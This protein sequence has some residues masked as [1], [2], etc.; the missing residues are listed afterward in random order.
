MK[1]FTDGQWLNAPDEWK[2]A[3]GVLTMKTQP[4]TDFWRK[5][6]Y[7]F[8]RDSGHFLGVKVDASFTAWLRV[9]GEFRAL[10]DQAGLMI[11]IDEQRWVKT[12]V[13]FTDGELFLSTVIT[14]GKS[15]WSVS[16][17]FKALEDF[18][19]RVTVNNGAIRIQASKD[20]KFWP[21][22]RLA[23]FPQAAQYLVGPMACTPESDGITAEFS[24]FE[25]GPALTTPL[26]DLT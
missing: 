10:Y 14:D 21:L 16:Q 22:L 20:G 19:I 3:G 23:P 5:T 13:E 7:G 26:H 4:K 2:V 24:E 15:D 17:P 6:F 9:K 1:N 11:R 18:Y 12:G 25:I 8:E